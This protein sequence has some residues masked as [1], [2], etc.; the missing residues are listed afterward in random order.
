[1]PRWEMNRLVHA[2]AGLEWV[3]KNNRFATLRAR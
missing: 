3:A 1:V 2:W